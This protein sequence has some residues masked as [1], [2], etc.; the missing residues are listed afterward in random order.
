MTNAALQGAQRPLPPRR[1]RSA[2][3]AAAGL[4][5]LGALAL[6]ACSPALLPGTDLKATR[7]NRPVYETVRAYAEALQRRDAAAVLALVAPDYYDTAGTPGPE[8]DLDRAGL[9]RSL[10]ADL[11]RVDSLRVEVAVKRIEVA[12]DQA[13]ADLFYESFFRVATPNGA[14]PRR[15]SDL[16]QMRLKRIGSDWKIVSGL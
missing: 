1:S 15:E 2:P 13:V 14:V 3:R 16:H 10:A 4:A 5:L 12:G 11:A 6:A 7:E 8:D 9:E